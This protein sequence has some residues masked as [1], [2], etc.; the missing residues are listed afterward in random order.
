MK[1]YQIIQTTHTNTV[2]KELKTSLLFGLFPYT[3]TTILLDTHNTKT[4]NQ[5]EEYLTNVLHLIENN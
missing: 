1:T 4:T 2:I 3:K 5:E